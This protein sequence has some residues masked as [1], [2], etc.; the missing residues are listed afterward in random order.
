MNLFIAVL[1]DNFAFC[2]NVEFA[3]ITPYHLEKFRTTWFKFTSLN[4]EAMKTSKR[5]DKRK[6]KL[7]L[8][9]G[10]HEM[11]TSHDH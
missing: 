11:S 4:A 7:G 9:Q 5:Q 8:T 6:H 1:L 2:A 10:E 3:D